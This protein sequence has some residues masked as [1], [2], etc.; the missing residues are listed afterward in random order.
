SDEV[1]A[2]DEPGSYRIGPM[3]MREDVAPHTD[4]WWLDKGYVSF[5]PLKMDMT[6]T[7]LLSQMPDSELSSA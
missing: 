4:R 3:V 2:G 5:T 7:N 1:L 6:A